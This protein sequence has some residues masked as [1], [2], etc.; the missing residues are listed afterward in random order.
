MHALALLVCCQE[1]VDCIV[2][3]RIAE[4]GWQAYEG[5]GAMELQLAHFPAAQR[6]DADKVFASDNAQQLSGIGNGL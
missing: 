5:R 3:E 6:V 4:V 1:G 2:H